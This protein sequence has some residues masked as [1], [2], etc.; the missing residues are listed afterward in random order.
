MSIWSTPS[1]LSIVFVD[2]SSY[3]RTFNPWLH[4]L[5]TNHVAVRKSQHAARETKSQVKMAKFRLFHK[6]R[7]RYGLFFSV[8]GGYF[9]PGYDF[10]LHIVWGLLPSRGAACPKVI[11]T[12]PCLGYS[13]PGD[14]LGLGPW[15]GW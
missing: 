1:N 2:I 4:F 5:V 9:R 8:K 11:K 10:L 14:M 13:V 15:F 3:L 6:N 12:H 7:K